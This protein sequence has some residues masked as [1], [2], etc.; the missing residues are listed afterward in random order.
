MGDAGEMQHGKHPEL[1]L[2]KQLFNFRTAPVSVIYLGDNVY[3]QGLPDSLSADFPRARAILDDQVALVKDQPADAYF[4]PGNHDWMQ[5]AEKGWQQILHQSAYIAALNLDNVHFLPEN[6]CPGPVEVHLSDNVVLVVMDSQWWLQQNPKPG[7][8]SD[9]AC[10]TPDEVLTRLNDIVFRNRDKILLFATHHPMKTY[11]IHGGDFRFK[12]HIFPLTDI[13]P[14]LY[15]PL[16]V[17]GSIY[18]ITRGVFGNIQ[19]TRHPIYKQMVRSVEEVLDKHPYCIRIAGHDHGLQ[20]IHSNGNTYIVSGG[21]SKYTR[22]KSGKG[23]AFA[24]ATTGFAVLEVLHNGKT[25]LKY[26][27]SMSAH[28]TE[29]LY[30]E[31][32]PSHTPV[33]ATSVTEEPAP[34]EVMVDSVSWPG[35]TAFHAGSFKRFLLGSNYRREWQSPVKVPVLDITQQFGGLKPLQRGGGHQTK[36]LRLE[37][38]TGKEYVLRSVQKAPNESA[39]PEAFQGTFVIDLVQDGVSASYPYAALSVPPMAVAAGVPHASPSLFYV[40]DDPAFGIYQKDFANNLYFLEEREP[41]AEGKNYNTGKVLQKLADDNDNAIDQPAVLRARMLDMFF[42]DFDRHEDQWRWNVEDK[43]K[44]KGKTYY[45]VPRDRDQ[46]F[47]INTGFIPWLAGQNFITPQLQGFRAHARNINTYNFNAKN[48]DR[49]FLNALTA[50]QW[51]QQAMQTIGEMTDSIIAVSLRQQPSTVYPYSADKI[52]ETLKARRKY[53][54]QE[55]T[56]YYRFLAK[57]VSIGGSDKRELFDVDRHEDGSVTVQ[58][59]KINKSGEVSTTLYSR[60]FLY[61][62]TKEIRLYGMGG[63]DKFVLHGNGQ[64]TIKVRIIGG[65]GEDDIVN[66]DSLAPASKTVVYDLSTEANHFTG[67]LQKRLSADPSINSWNRLGYK[68]D[69]LTPFLSVNYN[70]DDGIFL[71]AAFKYTIQGFRKEPFKLQHSLSVNHSLATKAYNFKYGLDL[72]DAVGKADFL[73][74]SELRAPNNTINY[75]GSGNES[76]YDKSDEKISYYRT[77]FT[78]GDLALMLRFKPTQHTSISVGPT[79]QYFA[80]DKDDNKGRFI[81]FPYLNGLDPVN[82]FKTKTYFGGQVITS[83]DDRNNKILPSRG[84]NWETKL[85]YNY[86]LNAASKNFTQ[87]SS[88]LSLFTSFST[89]ANLVI[90]TRFGGG[91]NFGGY[92]FYQAQFLSGTEN[93]RGFR[94]YRFAGDKMA[95]NNTELRIKLADFQ[96]YLFPGRL[97][98]LL[99]NDVGR[100]WTKGSSSGIWHDGYGGGLWVA[101]LNK[102][103]LTVSAAHSIEGTLPLVSFGFLF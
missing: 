97:G 79:F 72:T 5:G 43:G 83:I 100:V 60:T 69:V 15:I 89:S 37:D 55:A 56:Q 28:P 93:L 27:S 17:I 81:S 98:L 3:P 45:P 31:Q 80:M 102:F 62:E 34:R 53:L 40:P 75:F 26:Y 35:Y 90:G 23:T 85:R 51:K 73:I 6:G 32:L 48:F 101:P 82:L 59:F 50:E 41:E 96:T 63:D 95:Y 47:F 19:D 92:E 74:R 18:P 25:W 84:I 21:G 65:A 44:G 2:V 77:R 94:K 87:L 86:G 67:L 99:F 12:Q 33:P 88:E 14:S 39:L 76:V 16:P 38:R 1:D 68:Y 42:M 57:G 11:G 78:L 13:N 49:N 8:H 4:I 61:G 54:L 46:A 58:V 91:V 9:C 103:V 71:G 24:S 7:A 22:V 29:P 30:A 66:R 64:K 52:V 10:K 36:S 70:T 20:L